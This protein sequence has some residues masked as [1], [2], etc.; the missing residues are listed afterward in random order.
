M[1]GRLI[2]ASLR[3]LAQT[4][5][6]TED[7]DYE[8]K[9]VAWVISLDAEG[10]FLGLIPTAM[11]QGPKGKPVAKTMQI[12]RR[13]KRTVQD[14]PDFLV[15]K[16]EY[17]LGFLED[18]EPKRAK[19]VEPR[20]LLFLEQIQKAAAVTA[21][22]KLRAVVNFLQSESARAEVSANLQRQPYASNDLLCFEVDGRFAHEDPPVR[23]YFSN[24]RSD[25]GEPTSQCLLCGELRPPIDNHPSVQ[26]RGGSSS[27]IA[28][29]SFNAS[30]FESFGWERNENAPVCRNCAEA[31]TTG[32]RRLISIRYPDPRPPG[33][34][35]SRRFVSLTN[36]TTAVFWA[37][38]P[39]EGLD[40]VAEIFDKPDPE[41]VKAV[42][43]SPWTG[44]DPARLTA[45]FYCLLL[46][47]GQGRAILRGMHAG[48]LGDVEANV[49]QHFAAIAQ[50]SERPLALFFL[51]R[52]LAVQGK[53]DNLPPS[54]AG[55][56]F[57]AILFGFN[58][59][60][61]LLSAAIQRCRAEQQ[62]T[63]ERAA[64]LQLYFHRNKQRQELIMGLNRELSDTGYRLG[65][66]LAVLE[67]VQHK[68][69]PGL[70]KTIVDRY[71]GAASTRPVTVFPSLIH[72]A[73]H[74][75]SKIKARDQP[76]FFSLQGDIGEVLDGVELFPAHLSLEEQG[77]FALGYY[78][79]RYSRKNS[80]STPEE[81]PTAEMR[82]G[83][84]LND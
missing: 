63:R 65:R 54:L 64:I 17:V 26:L 46:S 28:L 73:Q 27:G 6:L 5:G 55:E 36:D 4:E 70:N 40:W 1:E 2:L 50:L 72:L 10:K 62:V 53:A 78:H 7:L 47:G 13:V 33:G 29:V 80:A 68:A 66:L 32:L 69:N 9:P 37:D 51:L 22:P 44:S 14:E 45:R 43:D 15:D 56:M 38:A 12:P 3:E 59:P 79:Q 41:A 34:I 35:F 18:A 21:N 23:A 11:P 60:Y 20:R 67:R 8:P 81:I 49:K 57:S 75:A 16:P 76:L 83:E 24:R 82:E 39:S 77:L 25:S 61:W 58:Y 48:V 31:Y 42:L 84:A 30:A 74:N 52:S 19:K 71:Y